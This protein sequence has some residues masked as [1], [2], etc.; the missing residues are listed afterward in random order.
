M[1]LTENRWFKYLF[2]SHCLSES[3]DRSV[4][5]DSMQPIDCN[6]LDSSVPGY[7]ILNIARRKKICHTCTMKKSVFWF[8]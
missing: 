1:P 6:L 4:V 8:S 7:T 5:S 3:D 2:S